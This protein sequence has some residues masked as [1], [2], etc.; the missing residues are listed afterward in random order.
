M[1]SLK[2]ELILRRGQAPEVELLA[3]LETGSS[4]N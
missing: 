4:F 3:K 1:P 2:I